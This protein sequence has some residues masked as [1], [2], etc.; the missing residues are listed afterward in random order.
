M[1]VRRNP[2]ESC[3]RRIYRAIKLL[4][5]LSTSYS[6]QLVI[7]DHGLYV[8]IPRDV[9]HDW[10]LLWRSLVLGHRK[11]MTEVS[12]RLLPSGGGILTA[13]LS[14]GFVTSTHQ[15]I[16]IF[17]CDC[18]SNYYVIVFLPHMNIRSRHLKLN[19]EDKRLLRERFKKFSLSDFMDLLQEL[20][21]PLLLAFRS[22]GLIRNNAVALGVDDSRRI[23]LQV[24]TSM[25]QS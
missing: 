21:R 17:A 20:P 18:A 10:C 23:A 7:L 24:Y 5:G 1:L 8:D 14:F 6:P 25:K 3:G 15:S 12:N 16:H 9:R 19:S 4:L 11:K 2:H 13:A 22:Q